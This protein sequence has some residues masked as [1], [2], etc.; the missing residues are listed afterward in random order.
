VD[1]AAEIGIGDEEAAKAKKVLFLV[2]GKQGHQDRP[3]VFRIKQGSARKMTRAE[4][5]AQHGYREG[6]L[7]KEQQVYW[8][9]ELEGEGEMTGSKAE[10]GEE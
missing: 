10:K 8:V 7:E 1:R 6:K 2:S 4:L 9:W 3:S 5:V